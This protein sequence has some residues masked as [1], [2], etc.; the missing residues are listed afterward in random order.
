M[1]KIFS[2]M[3]N[4]MKIMKEGEV[5]TTGVGLGLLVVALAE[6][7]GQGYERMAFERRPE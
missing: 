5:K 2:G 3:L 4:A 7:S 6:W 1:N